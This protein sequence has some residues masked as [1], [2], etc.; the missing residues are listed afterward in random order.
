MADANV[1]GLG[2]KRFVGW[3][4]EVMVVPM[5]VMVI[6]VVH[7]VFSDGVQM[8]DPCVLVRQSSALSEKAFLTKSNMGCPVSVMGNGQEEMI[9]QCY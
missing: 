3:G 2:K 8:E 6:E 5:H 1:T 7:L 4:V 9:Q